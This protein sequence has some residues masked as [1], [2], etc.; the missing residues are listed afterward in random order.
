MNCRRTSGLRTTL[1]FGTVLLAGVSTAPLFGLIGSFFDLAFGTSSIGPHRGRV[2]S[3]DDSSAGEDGAGDHGS[4]GSA[5][6]GPADD[7]TV[8]ERLIQWLACF[9]ETRIG[10]SSG[11]CRFRSS[12][13]RDAGAHI[14]AADVGTAVEM[15]GERWRHVPRLHF[16]EVWEVGELL[17]R[18]QLLH[19]DPSAEAAQAV[20]NTGRRSTKRLTR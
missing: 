18:A 11:E 20:E 6:K 19:P 4:G 15:A 7:R 16:I 13:I 12:N 8:A 1:M 2:A 14:D 10:C 5:G 17:C 3:A 9:R